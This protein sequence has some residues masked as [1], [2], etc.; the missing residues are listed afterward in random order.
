MDVPNNTRTITAEFGEEEKTYHCE[1]T[2]C[3]NDYKEVYFYLKPESSLTVY[4]ENT[5][6]DENGEYPETVDLYP[7]LGETVNRLKIIRRAGVSL[8]RIMKV[9]AHQVRAFPLQHRKPLYTDAMWKT[10]KETAR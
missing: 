1:V 6:P 8:N 4:A 2:D 5:V 7:S 9:S 10:Q 3:Y